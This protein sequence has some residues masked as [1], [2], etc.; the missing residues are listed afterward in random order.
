MLLLWDDDDDDGKAEE[1]QTTQRFMFVIVCVSFSI[2]QFVL[3]YIYV[4]DLAKVRKERAF[5]LSFFLCDKS[6]WKM[7][8]KTVSKMHTNVY[9]ELK[10]FFL[11]FDSV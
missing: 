3:G 7:E 4:F 1:R 10:N 2:Y 5:F 11:L 6:W 9:T 8:I